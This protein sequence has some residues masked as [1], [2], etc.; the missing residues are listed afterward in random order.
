[1]AIEKSQQN[2]REHKSPS[3]PR[4]TLS[5]LDKAVTVFAVVSGVLRWHHTHSPY[6]LKTIYSIKHSL[7][8]ISYCQVHS[9]VVLAFSAPPA[10]GIVRSL[11]SF[12]FPLF[13]LMNEIKAPLL[14]LGVVPVSQIFPEIKQRHQRLGERQ[15]VCQYCHQNMEM[16]ITFRVLYKGKDTNNSVLFPQLIFMVFKA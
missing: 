9:K 6:L 7:S 2:K 4:L 3:P 13:Y 16:K 11:I 10:F 14:H 8:Y 5:L 1:M 12:L 15:Q